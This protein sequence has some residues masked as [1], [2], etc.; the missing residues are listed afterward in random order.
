MAAQWSSNSG[1]GLNLS[2]GQHVAQIV[3]VATTPGKQ[4]PDGR[5][6]KPQFQWQLRVWL[7]NNWTERRIWT[8]TAFVDLS[9][10]TDPQF[11]PKLVKL[12]RACQHPLPQSAEEAAAWQETSLIGAQFVLE[13]RPNPDLPS[14]TETIYRPYQQYRPPSAPAA[15][16]P[17]APEVPSVPAQLP[18]PVSAPT[19][20]VTSGRTMADPTGWTPP[21]GDPFA[22]DGPAPLPA[23]APL[24]TT[25]P[26]LP[27]PV[28]WVA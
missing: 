24:P 4:F 27:A 8:G 15:A 23:A 17:A 2:A 26:P 11:I 1:G 20:P 21:T 25:A 16:A 3:G 28:G 10:I 7:Q 5:P 9:G 6:P 19:P 12:V 14:I 18:P 22:D 13:I